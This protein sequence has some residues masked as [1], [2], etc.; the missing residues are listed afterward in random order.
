MLPRD[1]QRERVA[2]ESKRL[3]AQNSKQPSPPKTTKVFRE[4]FHQTTK[5]LEKTKII[6]WEINLSKDFLLSL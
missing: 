1:G 3:Q 2:K 5:E 4:N 6:Q